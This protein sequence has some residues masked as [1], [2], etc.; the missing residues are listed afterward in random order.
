MVMSKFIPPDTKGIQKPK[1]Q[2]LREAGEEIRKLKHE[3]EFRDQTLERMAWQNAQLRAA[4]TAL[5]IKYELTPDAM[6][7][8]VDAYMAKEEAEFMKLNEEKK[9]QFMSDIKAGKKVNFS[10]TENP[11]AK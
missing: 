3:V 4:I 8:I 5:G 7:E 2:F 9:A 11:D 1:E 6:K 10:V